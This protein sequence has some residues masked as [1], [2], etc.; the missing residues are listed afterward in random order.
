MALTLTS[1]T[2]NVVTFEENFDRAQSFTTTPGHNGWT[3]ADTS[4]AGTP[5][6]LT[7]TE[8]G[9]AAKL[10]LASNSEAENVCLYQNDVLMWDLAQ[11]QWVE[12]VLKVAGFDSVTELVAGVG[13]ARNDTTDS[14]A[15]NAWFKINGS[16][17]TAYAETDDGTT[18]NDDV[19]CLAT[20]SG[21]KRYC[22]DF[23]KGLNDVRFYQDGNRVAYGTTFNMSAISA[24]QNV[25]PIIQLQKASG[26]GVGSVTVSRIMAQ[27]A[28]AY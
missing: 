4:S 15:V 2:R 26:T 9:G 24:G 20:G 21:Y 3:I 5:T 7:I 13:S 23:C 25:Q 28:F 27:F 16:T 14:V 19:A 1:K 11:L 17:P 8:D 6:Y 22:I 10:T 18:D 12:F